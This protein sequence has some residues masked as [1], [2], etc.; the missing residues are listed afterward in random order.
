MR[1]YTN[2]ELCLIWLDSFIGLEYKHKQTLLGLI[3]GKTDL[4]ELLE[5]GRD[6]IVA[7]IGE[8][9]YSTL[10]HSANKEYLDFVLSSLERK[11]ITVVTIESENYPQSLIKTPV[12]PLV[13]YC[14]GDES[15]LSKKS[16]SIVG[17]RKSIPQSLKIAENYAET[18]CSNGYVVVTGIAEGVDS[19]VLK[20]A[21]KC[22]GKM[23]S[24]LAG[25]FD[26]LYPASNLSLVQEVEKRGLLI[27]EH[28]PEI[29][30]KPYLFPVRN[31]IIAGLSQATVVVSGGL[32]SGTIYTAEYAEEYGREVFAVP[33]SVGVQSGAGCNEL[34][35]RGAMLTDKPED[36]LSFYGIEIKRE[37]V[38]LTP[39]Q[40]EIVTLLKD[41][42][43]HVENICKALNKKVFE[44]TPVISI[45]EINKIIVK[46]GTN[47][48]GLI[49]S[50][51]EE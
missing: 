13:L 51:L 19:T 27:T 44:I 39:E 42:E 31:R 5:K 23:I 6:Y 33:Y 32:R 36:V 37:S 30:P 29:T 21:L 10:T 28:A 40:K 3:Q 16:I 14:K 46:N 12:P 43:M 11:G 8:K 49:R 17:S 35:K 24:V 50:D 22:G 9:E 38:K 45:M 4:K 26:N 15:L 20:T 18:I 34:I 1:K 7:N 47:V 41:G 48:Y 2:S 25:G